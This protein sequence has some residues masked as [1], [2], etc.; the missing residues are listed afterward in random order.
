MKKFKVTV[1]A[2]MVISFDENS[3]E[4]KELWDG[5]IESIDSDA[6]HESFVQNIASIISRY[7]T[8]ELIEG[9]GHVQLFGKNQKFFHEGEYKEQPGI[10]NVEVETDIN[11]AVEFEVSY[12]EDIS[13]E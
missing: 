12:T 1:E 6:D 7:G 2:E 8:Q 5:Y 10:V 11:N 3:E 4:F 13:E 9:V